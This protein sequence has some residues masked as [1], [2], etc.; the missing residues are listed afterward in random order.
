MLLPS[1]TCTSLWQVIPRLEVISVRWRMNPKTISVFLTQ[2]GKDLGLLLECKDDFVC[3][4]VGVHV[5]SV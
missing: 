2:T 3:T 4:T 5:D 1:H